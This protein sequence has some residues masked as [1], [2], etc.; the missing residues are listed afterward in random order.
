MLS[1]VVHT[2]TAI[3]TSIQIIDA[4]VKMRKYISTNLIEQKYINNLVLENHK[5][6]ELVIKLFLLM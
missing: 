6:I 3:Q 2:T 1:S 4:F 5:R